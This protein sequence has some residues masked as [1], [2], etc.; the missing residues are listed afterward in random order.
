M[1]ATAEFDT[2]TDSSRERAAPEVELAVLGK[3]IPN[4]KAI[5]DVPALAEDIGRLAA[6][7]DDPVVR[8]GAVLDLLKQVLADATGEIR[9]RL[10]ATNDGAACVRGRAWLMDQVIRLI[11]TQAA[12]R[13]FPATNPTTSE[14]I[15]VTAVG[16]YGRG[17]LAPQSDIDLLFLLPYKQTARCEQIVEYT[18]YM[19][20]DLG[21]KVGHSTRSVSECIR[22][23]HADI[24][25]RTAMLE[26]RF[27]WGDDALYDE[28]REKFMADIASSSPLEFVEQKLQE[29][30]HRHQRMGDSRYV[31]E[32]NIKDGKGGLRDLHTLFWISKYVYRIDDVSELVERGVLDLGEA[33][34]F[35]QA[36]K[37][38]WTIRCHLHYLTGRPEER[39][40]FDVQPVIAERL[41]Y[42]DRA[43]AMA[44]ERFMKHYYL[45][46]KDVGDLTRIFCAAIEAEYKRRRRRFRLPKMFGEER[47]GDFRVEGDRITVIDDHAFERDPVNIIRLF[48]E[49]HFR[50]LMI[51]PHALRVITQNQNLINADL[52]RDPEANRLFLEILS[53]ERGPERNLRRMSEARVLGKFVPDFGRVVAQMQFDMYHTYTV[54]EH[55]LVCLGVLH[56]IEQGELK[57]IAPIATDVVHKVLSRRALYV[58]MFLHDIAKG[59]G[60]NHSI[61][62]E[63]VARRVCPRLGMTE[64]ETDTVAW[65][66][67]WHLLMS[68]T[69]FKRDIH[70]P[71]TVEDFARV[72]QSPE[73]LRLLLVLTVADIRG[74]G[75]HVWNGW[76][77]QLLRDLYYATDEMLTGA[78]SPAKTGARV[79]AAKNK[80]TEQ[81]VG[82]T[83]AEIEAH[84]GLGYDPYWLGFDTDT[85]VRHAWLV[86][87]AQA[88][89]ARL[90]VEHRLDPDREVTEVTVYAADHPGLFSRIA[91][92]MSAVGAN[93]VDARIVT[94]ANG[95]AIDTFMIQDDKRQMFD[96]PDRLARL[97]S[98]IE[99]TLDGSLRLEEQLEK[100]GTLT[101]RRT[102]ALKVPPRVLID[103]KASV[104]HT[105]IEVNAHDEPGVL[106][107][108]TR[109]LARVGVQIHS[110]T[111]STYGE[112]FVDVFYVKDVFGLKIDSA[113]KLDEI[114]AA[115]LEALGVQ[116][117]PSKPEPPKPEAS[118][119]EVSKAEPKKEARKKQ[120]S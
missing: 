102:R 73:R 41:G 112:R 77:A 113:R 4:R 55:T 26:S 19:L 118:K 28:M 9:R 69:A 12:D 107:R 111:V 72:V 34:R 59:R 11:A 61:L 20:W 116:P 56:A 76:K 81:L 91:G 38:L 39:L 50:D 110:A 29:S 43:G 86:R 88:S 14:R 80:V 92:A 68:D 40:T 21:L 95:M 2:A 57:D 115:L 98:A 65:L 60:G 46:A 85:L 82:W 78:S 22:Q 90:V 105:V 47:F 104:T 93:I 31:V 7:H 16:G 8:R 15:A 87:R 52:R 44:V 6:E 17:E 33:Q 66:I 18:L 32:P 1:A 108:M 10:E 58:A 37:R 45:T 99:R 74:V 36:Q 103:Q 106:H 30:D 101:G 83:D 100:K 63:R 53:S 67:R 35:A 62:G 54:D 13:E 114:R 70:D 64:E 97:A 109:A 119:P 27:L 89:D 71:K 51:H 117:E 96:R 3:R 48:H 94:L 120:G 23:A 24:T 5:C 25:I 84:L 75:P 49:S 42:T 79:A